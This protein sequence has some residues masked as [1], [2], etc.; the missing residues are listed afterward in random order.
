[1]KTYKELLENAT[2][3]KTRAKEYIQKAI[4]KLGNDSKKVHRHILDN[5]VNSKYGNESNNYIQMLWDEYKRIF[6]S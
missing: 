1:M 3:D 4:K 5:V 6:P 2:Q